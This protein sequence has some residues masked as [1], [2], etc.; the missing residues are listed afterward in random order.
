MTVS[1][2]RILASLSAREG[3]SM[4]A[5]ADTTAVDRTTLTRALDRM[6]AQGLVERRQDEFDRRTARLRL[7]A[8]GRKLYERALPIV[9]RQNELAVAGM[10]P[11]EVAA[12]R[13][14]LW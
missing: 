5:L 6:R 10:K 13:Q 11:A 1:Q 2:W 12:F 4:T 14:Q 3:S 7:S 9:L 8:R